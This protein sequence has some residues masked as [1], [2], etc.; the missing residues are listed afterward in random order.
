MPLCQFYPEPIL[1]SAGRVTGTRGA[2]VSSR[3]PAA[4]LGAGGSVRRGGLAVALRVLIVDDNRDAADSLALLFVLKGADA[5]V[6]YGGAEAL[7]RLA[8]FCPHAGLFDIHMPGMT[9]LELAR[10]VRELHSRCP[11]LLVA[12]TGV[13][14]EEAGEATAAAGFDTHLTKPADPAELDRVLSAF[15]REHYPGQG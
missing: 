9:G 1:S 3:S 13:G 6:A 15:L 2:A 14:D 10:R 5:R 4:V 11:L 8:D 12:V 7:A